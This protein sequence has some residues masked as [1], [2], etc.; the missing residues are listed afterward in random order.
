MAGQAIQIGKIHEAPA[1]L[2]RVVQ[3][4]LGNLVVFGLRV[5]DSLHG[6]LGLCKGLGCG[7]FLLFLPDL[8][9]VKQ[10]SFDMQAIQPT[11]YTRAEPQLYVFGAVRIDLKTDPLCERG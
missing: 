4:A 11:Q 5:I 1:L 7:G 6:C 8:G 2:N 3:T 10:P 9:Q